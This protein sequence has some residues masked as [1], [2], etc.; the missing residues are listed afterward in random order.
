MINIHLKGDLK[1]TEEV[2]ERKPEQLRLIEVRYSLSTHFIIIIILKKAVRIRNVGV[3]GIKRI[4]GEMKRKYKCIHCPFTAPFISMLW[5][6]SRYGR[7][8]E[9]G[10]GTVD[11]VSI[12]IIFCCRHHLFT[13]SSSSSSSLHHCS[14]CTF[15]T[16]LLPI[17]S[18]HLSMHVQARDT[19]PC[20]F[21]PFV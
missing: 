1:T 17:F 18:T 12:G 21:C 20:E 14:D 13:S 2:K 15:T 11:G 10:G 4:G 9:R 5:R 16:S 6:H 19:F 7:E 8:R 3:I